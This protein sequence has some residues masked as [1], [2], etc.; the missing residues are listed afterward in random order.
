MIVVRVSLGVL[1]GGNA[2]VLPN[3]LVTSSPQRRRM[4]SAVVI[5]VGLA[6]GWG[7]VRLGPRYPP[8]CHPFALSHKSTVAHH[9]DVEGGLYEY[10]RIESCLTGV[11]TFTERYFVGDTN[12]RAAF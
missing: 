4:S 9:S 11:Y 12:G 3:M 8:I 5:D 1:F 10:Q 2:Q 6:R 7:F